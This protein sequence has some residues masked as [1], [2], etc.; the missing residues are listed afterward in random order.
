MENLL[1]GGLTAAKALAD[2]K[3]GRMRIPNGEY[4]RVW[5]VLGSNDFKEGQAPDVQ[6]AK[7]F[8]NL[9]ELYEITKLRTIS[10]GR[11]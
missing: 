11:V 3:S 9:Q 8:A 5:I 4:W 2:L 10:H 6:A 7:V 1:K